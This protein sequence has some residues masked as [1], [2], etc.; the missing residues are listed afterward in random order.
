MNCRF[1]LPLAALSLSLFLLAAIQ[2]PAAEGQLRVGTAKVNITPENP[3]EPVHD[4]VFVRS[5][6][7]DVEGTRVALIAIDLVIFTSDEI[8]RICQEKYDIDLL[9]I[10]SSHTHSGPKAPPGANRNYYREFYE[11]KI[12]EAI[13]QA[14]ENMFPARISAGNRAFPQLG[15]NR[16]IIREDGRARESWFGDDHYRR[17][18]PDRIPFGPVDPEVGVIKITDMEG[19]PRVIVVN[20]AMHSDIMCFNYEISADFPGVTTRLIEEA[21]GN[22]LNCLFVNG[23]AGNVKSLQISRRR[24]GPDDPI[25]GEYHV[26]ERVGQLLA[27]EAIRLARQ[28][29][30]GPEK[31][32]LVQKSDSMQF[33]GR[34]NKNLSFDVSIATLLINNNIVIG[35]S[36]GE[37]FVQLQLEWKEK[38][39]LADAIP[40]FFGFTWLAG[41]WQGYTPDVRSAALGGFGADQSGNMIEVGSGERIINKL[42]EQFYTLNGLMRSAP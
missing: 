15:F 18:N 30:V 34:Y 14:T 2:A 6:I 38:L 23:A 20:Y 39:R 21:F 4:P 29:P 11:S 42:I 40:L 33:T 25:K 31:T 27:I 41:D 13:E 1:F 16:L 8:V 3:T 5:L 19:Q 10:S 9:L 28:L 12:L 7:L 37:L 26:M 35:V 22:G 17:E 36:P 24:T 32:S